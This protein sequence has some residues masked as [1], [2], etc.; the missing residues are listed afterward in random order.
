MSYVSYGGGITINQ[1]TNLSVKQFINFFLS[2]DKFGK[3]RSFRYSKFH[4]A[5]RCSSVFFPIREKG[6]CSVAGDNFTLYFRSEEDADLI[7]NKL[8]NELR[9]DEY[10]LKGKDEWVVMEHEPSLGFY[11]TI[12]AIILAE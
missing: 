6:K 7:L 2:Q 9:D 5:E 4:S 1:K 12:A 11:D 3:I 10:N 8:F